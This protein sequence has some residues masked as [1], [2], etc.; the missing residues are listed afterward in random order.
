MAK[1]TMLLVDNDFLIRSKFDLECIAEENA[2]ERFLQ[3][4]NEELGTG[5]TA[6]LEIEGIKEN[7]IV[8]EISKLE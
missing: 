8:F 2:L 1:I 7:P 4:M 5:M 3:E 6:H